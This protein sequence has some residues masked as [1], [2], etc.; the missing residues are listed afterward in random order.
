[1]HSGAKRLLRPRVAA[2]VTSG[3]G[4][5]VE[6]AQIRYDPMACITPMTS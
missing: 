6:S 5:V 1:M 4:E 3:M 2:G